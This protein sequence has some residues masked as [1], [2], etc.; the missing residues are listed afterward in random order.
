M[1]VDKRRALLAYDA[2]LLSSEGRRRVEERL[3]G[4]EVHRRALA[5]IR[6]LRATSE[7]AADL[8]PAL[9]LSWDSIADV[10]ARSG[11]TP[12]LRALTAY[13]EE[14]LSDEARAR[15]ERL[16]TPEDRQALAKLQ[17]LAQVTEETRRATSQ[18]DIDFA[19]MELALRREAK[20]AAR[21]TSGLRW[22]VA[23]AAAAAVLLGVWWM[24]T[25][26]PTTTL[27]HRERPMP[28]RAP[29]VHPALIG[30]VTALFG[31][32]AIDGAPLTLGQEVRAAATLRTEGAM[33]VRLAEGT[34]FVLE[35]D[36]RVRRLD[37]GGIELEL[38]SGRVASQVQSG[39]DYRVHAG[40]YEVR[41][42]GTRFSVVR[43]DEDLEVAL[44]E[45][46]VEVLRDG[47]SLEM[48]HAPARWRSEGE[49]T[50]EGGVPEP[51]GLAIE[52]L[53]ASAPVALPPSERF[54]RWELGE[55]A[56]PAGL[57]VHLRLPVGPLLLAAFDER[58]RRY[59]VE[60]QVLPEGLA[61]EETSLSSTARPRQGHL[62]PEVIASVVRPRQRWL[63]RCYEHT[64][65]RTAPELGGRFALRVTLAGDGRVV[66]A[67]V[68]SEQETPP[69]F[70]RCLQAEARSWQFPN[71]GGRMHFDLPLRFR[72]R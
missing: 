67:R 22:G 12:R 24:R 46:V 58:D 3:L 50:F 34:G 20:R 64:L 25:P 68:V 57:P 30:E 21:T 31:S 23:F 6:A 42:H 9:S 52:T 72:T 66:S 4:Q 65:R 29:E 33:H 48:L 49:S 47:E 39:T 7:E 5:E 53:E 1:T 60:L 38:A 16:M 45:G 27:A 40:G 51:R 36:S 70:A 35:G 2:D 71:P 37:T 15:L 44:D 54:V 56:Y 41:V 61:V 18:P 13:V 32:G 17:A 19:R 10:L 11:R 55:V 26:E 43:D 59:E 28:T 62:E 8:Q 63:R 69:S 14:T